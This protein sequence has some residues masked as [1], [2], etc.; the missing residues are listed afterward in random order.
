MKMERPCARGGHQLVSFQGEIAV[1]DH[2]YDQKL[3]CGPADFCGFGSET[4]PRKKNV[5]KKLADVK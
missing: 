1:F 2:R 4:S 5:E 3:L